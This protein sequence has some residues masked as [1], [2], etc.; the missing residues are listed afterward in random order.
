M[1]IAALIRAYHKP[2][3]LDVLLDRL[4]GP[5]WAPYVHIDRKADMGMFDRSLGKATFLADR[6][7]VNWG[8][9]SQVEATVMQFREALRDPEITHFYN[10]SG[11]CY[12]VKSDADI[13]ARIAGLAPG[14]ANLIE[15]HAMPASHK[16]LK[17]Y[18]RR[19]PHDVRNPLA[20]LV[21]KPLFACLP[22]RPLS[23]LRGIRL[24][25]GGC[26]WLFERETVER[27]VRFLDE[28]PWFWAEFR[29]SDCPD[30]M[31][32]HTLLAP[33]GV[34]VGGDAPT[35]DIWVQG[36]AHPETITPAMHAAFIAGPAL[37]AR[38][39]V[40]FHPAMS[41]ASVEKG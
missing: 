17:R 29:L 5:L 27:I 1:K 34:T 36:K 26:W 40:D 15:M 10:M 24:Y 19:W 13:E 18:Q 21:A 30:E 7:Q 11:Q 16:P 2:E 39:Y 41:M 4:A 28:N 31:L 23:R 37:F 38:K 12:P 9:L 20:R 3:H 35:G 8:G 14:T 32:F 22:D 6:I 33:L 25:G